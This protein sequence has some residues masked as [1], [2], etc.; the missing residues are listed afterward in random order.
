MCSHA[1]GVTCQK[2]GGRLR[3]SGIIMA[4]GFGLL[5]VDKARIPLL[6]ILFEVYNVLIVFASFGGRSALR[7]AILTKRLPLRR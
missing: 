3:A 7:V 2:G 1:V 4:D 6:R 5:E